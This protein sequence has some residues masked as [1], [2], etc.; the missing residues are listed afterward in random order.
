M[1]SSAYDNFQA[2]LQQKAPATRKTY[3]DSLKQYMKHYRIERH[4]LLL[5]GTNEALEDRIKDFFQVIRNTEKSF[6]TANKT[7]WAL[8]K[9]YSANRI[10]LNWDHVSSFMPAKPEKEQLDRPYSHEE[11]SMLL[12]EADLRTKTAILVM[13]TSGVRRGALAGLRID[14]DLI[15]LPTYDT[16]CLHVYPF[17]Q[18]NHYYTFVTPQASQFIDEYKA[19]RDKGFLFGNKR[20]PSLPVSDNIFAYD[21][22]QLLVKT[23]LRTPNK[24]D[25][26]QSVQME[27]GFRKF[28]RTTLDMCGIDE[29][30]AERL[31]GHARGLVKTYSIPE[32]LEWMQATKYYNAIQSLTF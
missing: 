3:D 31:T 27:H 9:F 4:D 26:R 17:D 28:F 14:K 10:V 20:D 32:P 30:Y 1:P 19:G 8:R 18:K 12:S 2:A 25:I 5:N 21:I 11:I 16:Y 23:G 13:S 24:A 29:T 15:W 7:F 22:W 6:S